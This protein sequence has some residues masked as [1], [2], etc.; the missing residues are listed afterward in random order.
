MLDM[1]L[2]LREL[3][4]RQK[5]PITSAYGLAKASKG[6]INQTT[7][8]RLLDPK[9]PPKGVEFATLD[10][11]AATLKCKPSELLASDEE[12]DIAPPVEAAVKPRRKRA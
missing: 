10:A 9:R 4:E 6:A 2:R 12:P 7:A 3:M 5:P 1:R 11:I 8:L